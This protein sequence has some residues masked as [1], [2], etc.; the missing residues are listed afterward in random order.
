MM[1][2]FDMF[3]VQE[4]LGQ[5]DRMKNF[6]EEIRNEI[7][8]LQTIMESLHADNKRLQSKLFKFEKLLECESDDGQKGTC[9]EQLPYNRFRWCR[10]CLNADQM[11]KLLEEENARDDS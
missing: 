9:R 6:L 3:N 5:Q 11:E 1:S 2:I 4:I 7:K 8:E 10:G